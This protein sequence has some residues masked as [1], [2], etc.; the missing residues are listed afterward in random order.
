MIDR[1]PLAIQIDEEYGFSRQ[2]S[3]NM[4]ILVIDV[5][6]DNS[7]VEIFINKGER[8]FCLRTFNTKKRANKILLSEELPVSISVFEV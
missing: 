4:D 8:V 1:R 2:C 3:I 7:F 6:V 5:F